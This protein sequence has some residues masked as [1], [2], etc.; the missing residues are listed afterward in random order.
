[1]MNLSALVLITTVLASTLVEKVQGQ[2]AVLPVVIFSESTLTQFSQLAAQTGLDVILTAAGP[3][4]V[5]AP[6]DDAFATLDS[7]FL[8]PEWSEHLTEIM[9]TH[10]AE[11]LSYTTG[12]WEVGAIVTAF[13]EM[14]VTVTSVD[15]TFQINNVSNVVRPDILANNG[16]LHIMDTV[17]LPPDIVGLLNVAESQVS[18]LLGLLDQ[19][20]LIDDLQGDGPFTL[21]APSNA[22]FE[23]LGADELATLQSD[24]EALSSILLF[25]VL[26]GVHITDNLEADGV[27]SL[28]TL[29]GEDMMIPFENFL[30]DDFLASNGVVRKYTT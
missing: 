4:T 18:A 10:V 5:F 28:P 2:A 24:I 1:M 13:S 30:L 17:L 26:P 21:L 15:P 9:Y 22:A 11:G 25:H 27:T 14:D 23:A 7:K 6:N 19:T 8:E 3:Y 29:Q 20:G 16:V 12:Q